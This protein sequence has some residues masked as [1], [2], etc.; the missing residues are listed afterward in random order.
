MPQ[1]GP[2]LDRR[3]K[4]NWQ[5]AVS[6]ARSTEQ[7]CEAQQLRYRVFALEMGARLT[8]PP[9]TEP[10]LDADHFDSFCDHLLVH[11]RQDGRRAR[12]TL[13][14]TY[15]VLSPAAA[16]RAGGL[17]MDTEFDLAP[18][19]AL[20]P[21][22]V[23]LGRSCVDPAWRSGAVIMALWSALG[24]Y[25]RSHG[26]QTMIGCASIPLQANPQ[27]VADLW[28]QLSLTHLVAPRWQVK[29][30]I[31][32]PP[33]VSSA[34]NPDTVPMLRLCTAAGARI[35]SGELALP[36]LIKGYLRCGACLLGPPALDLAFNTADL[37]MMLQVGDLAPRYRRHFLGH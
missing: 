7:V 36:P 28:Q 27:G 22:A 20:R 3:A 30:L 12:T 33:D 25:M 8:P 2:A 6:W 21:D 35:A 31:G 32:M 4:E 9:G 23:E 1:A 5:L 13:V 19:T 16:R 18:L 15:R 14:G 11:A 17:Y 34:G 29:P 37:P 26:A 10:G 24:A